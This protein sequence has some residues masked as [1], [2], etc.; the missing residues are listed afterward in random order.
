MP[1][2]FL[3]IGGL[4]ALLMV[5]STIHASSPAIKG[6][7]SGVELCPQFFC[8]AAVFNG[9]C[10]CEVDGRHTIGFFWVAV[11]HDPLPAE[12]SS[13]AI[14]GGKWNL[15]TLRGSFSG[16]VLNGWITNNGNNT[17][18]V[19]ATLRLRKGGNGDVTV[20][21]VLDH[22]EFPP[23]FEGKLL[24]PQSALDSKGRER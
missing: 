24:Q 13:A 1:K 16:R 2:S 23:T 7:I 19:T 3:M 12:L 14:F 21:G 4:A 9:T 8:D 6:E 17:F 5:V 11:E 18:E 22:T 20:S 10:D 15:T